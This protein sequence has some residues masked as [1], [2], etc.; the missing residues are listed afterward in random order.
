MHAYIYACL[1]TYKF[2]FVCHT[3]ELGNLEKMSDGVILETTSSTLCSLANSSS[4]SA[5]FEM[6]C[7]VGQKIERT[8]STRRQELSKW[9]IIDVRMILFD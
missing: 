4:S 2:P 7:I 3:R 5:S 6:K 1:Y 9:I 8:A